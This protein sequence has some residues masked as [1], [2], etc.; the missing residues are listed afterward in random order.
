[1]NRKL[2]PKKVANTRLTSN[3]KSSKLSI[4]RGSGK[5]YIR[6]LELDFEKSLDLDFN[7]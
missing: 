2:V 1:M 7:E 4:K 3:V 6:I 5:E